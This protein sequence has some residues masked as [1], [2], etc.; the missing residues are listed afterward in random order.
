MEQL[1]NIIVELQLGKRFAQLKQRISTHFA[2]S[3]SANIF[4]QVLEDN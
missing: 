2:M 4:S 3:G 1:K